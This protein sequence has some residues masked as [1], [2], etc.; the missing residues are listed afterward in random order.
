MHAISDGGV[1]NT[2]ESEIQAESLWWKHHDLWY[3]GSIENP[4]MDTIREWG[5]KVRSSAR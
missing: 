2:E 1:A 3:V 4:S 5:G